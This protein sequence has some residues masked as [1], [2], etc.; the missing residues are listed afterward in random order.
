M[1][2]S[3]ALSSQPNGLMPAQRRLARSSAASATGVVSA[4]AT[5]GDVEPAGLG[6]LQAHE[7]RGDVAGAGDAGVVHDLAVEGASDVE[8]QEGVAGGRDVDD[9]VLAAAEAEQVAEGTEDGDFCRARRAHV[10]GSELRPVCRGGLKLLG[11][12]ALGLGVGVDPADVD[13][14]GQ[15][16]AVRRRS[17][18]A[19]SVVARCTGSSRR[20]RPAAMRTAT[21]VFH[22]RV[23]R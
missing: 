20:A 7:G 17:R 15:I 14:V 2:A 19:E 10:L 1:P 4:R 22:P 9:D 12:V 21:L 5:I 23:C 8:Q 11:G 6:V 13:G 3:T 16:D 18:P